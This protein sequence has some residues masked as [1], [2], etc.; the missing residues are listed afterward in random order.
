MPVQPRILPLCSLLFVRLFLPHQFL[1]RLRGGRRR[2][3]KA[4]AQQLSTDFSSLPHDPAIGSAPTRPL[5]APIAP[6]SDPLVRRIS[7]AKR[8]VAD[9][10]VGKVISKL[11]ALHPH[12]QGSTPKCPD[13]APLLVHVD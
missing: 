5:S 9:R 7:H 2:S 4:L 6:P 10:L 11:R 13:S 1:F 12:A 3:E 8:L